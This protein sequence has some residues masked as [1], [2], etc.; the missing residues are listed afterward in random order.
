MRVAISALSAKCPILKATS[1][2][3]SP[4]LIS[5]TLAPTLAATKAVAK[6]PV[7]ITPLAQ[8]R[9]GRFTVTALTDG[10]ADMP[11]NYF[12]GR[13]AAEV[14]KAAVAQFTARK[15]GVRFLFNQYV[16][17]DG[18]RRILIDAGAA[19]SIGQTG[20][21]PKAPAALG[22]QRDQIDAVIVTHLHQDHMGGLI[23]GGKKQLSQ[24]RALYRS[25]RHHSLDRP[26]QTQRCARLSEDQLRHGG[27][28]CASL[29]ETPGNRRRARDHPGCFH[30]RSDGAI[31]LAIS[32]FGSKMAIRT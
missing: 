29:P 31:H 8:I 1:T 20:E 3:S 25:A 30:Y 17:E 12:P 14:E 11:Y 4:K 18:E 5:A 2:C 13:D 9:I 10:Y 6:T 21:L 27:G 23:A 32:A 26:G 19:G 16:I 24:R 28:C 15:S 22:L 7:S